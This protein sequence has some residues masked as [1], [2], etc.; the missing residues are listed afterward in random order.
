MSKKR[1]LKELEESY[2]SGIMNKDEYLKK[3]KEIEEEPEEN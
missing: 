1:R 3:K 2:E